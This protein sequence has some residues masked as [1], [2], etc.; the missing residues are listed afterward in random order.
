MKFHRW[1]TISAGALILSLALST[2]ALAETQGAGKDVIKLADSFGRTGVYTFYLADELGFF[3]EEGIKPEFVGVVPPPQL[4]AAVMAGR[5]DVGGAHVNRTIAGINA[6]A[7]I[8]AV[9]AQT[10]TTKNQPHMVF[11]VPANSPIKSARDLIGKRLAIMAYGGCNEYTPYEWM[12]KNGVSKPKGKLKIIVVPPG[13]EIDAVKHGDADVAGAHMNPADLPKKGDNLRVLF[14]DYEVWGTQGGATPLYFSQKFIKEKPDVV[15]RFV[16]AIGKTNNWINANPEKAKAIQGKRTKTDPSQI[17]V[18]HYA[19]DGVIPDNTVKLWIDLLTDYGEIKPGI[20]T[21]D[22]Y[23]NSFNQATEK[24][25][26]KGKK[27]RAASL[28]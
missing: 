3:A 13:K 20:A 8:K 27:S 15:R 6:G 7:K 14:T 21:A 12:R 5:L 4:V 22:I 2:A 24:T 17:N 1:R 23:T 26:K 11:V 28:R 19:L 10:E 16:K 18:N 9:V 25:E